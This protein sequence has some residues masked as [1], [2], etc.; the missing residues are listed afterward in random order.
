MY[1][2]LTNC[3]IGDIME[4]TCSNLAS[5]NFSFFTPKTMNVPS[6]II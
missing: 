1:F 3:E 5:V 2:C 6:Q 4:V